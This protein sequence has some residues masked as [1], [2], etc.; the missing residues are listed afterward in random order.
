MVVSFQ[1][2]LGYHCTIPLQNTQ[3]SETRSLAVQ[4]AKLVEPR[5][6]VLALSR[7]P[8]AA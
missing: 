3:E 2:G 4:Q 1:D 8:Q 7:S 6:F 5:Q